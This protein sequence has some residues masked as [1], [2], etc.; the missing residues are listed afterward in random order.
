MRALLA[1]AAAG[2]STDYFLLPVASSTGRS[3]LSVYRERV[4]AY[5][6]YHQL[7][8]RWPKWRYSL[9]GE[10]DKTGHPLI[11]GESLDGAKP[12]LLVHVPG[13]MDGNLLVVE[14]KSLPAARTAIERDF[15]KLRAFLDVGYRQAIMLT[16][17]G[18]VDLLGTAVRRSALLAGPQSEIETWHHAKAGL[19]AGPIRL[20]RD[21]GE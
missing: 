13:R 19:R 21:A 12:D 16:F 4:Y 7:R 20:E 11:R 2:V 5:E 10:V 6:L 1:N 14:I 9:A 15:L 8:A 18:S 17:G 3:S